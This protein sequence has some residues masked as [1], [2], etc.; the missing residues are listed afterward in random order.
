MIRPEDRAPETASGPMLRQAAI[1]TDLVG[2]SKIWVGFVELGPGMRSAVHHHGEAESAIY[3]I[4]GQARF[5]CGDQLEASYDAEPGD[6]V[7]VPPH[8]AHVEINR[9]DNE[10]LLTVVAR[11]TQKAVVFNLPTPDPALPF[12]NG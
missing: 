4:S 12:S 9:S 6:F 2:A 1:S 8:V 3:I 11:S 5:L 10:P 7:W